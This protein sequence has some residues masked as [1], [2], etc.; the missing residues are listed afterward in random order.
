MRDLSFAYIEVYM[1]WA[2]LLKEARNWIYALQL[3]KGEV[4]LVFLVCCVTFRL[5]TILGHRREMTAIRAESQAELERTRARL[6]ALQ[7][8]IDAKQRRKGK[9]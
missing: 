5:G 2:E 6:S 3:T 4:F 1:D 8:K 9:K 7:I